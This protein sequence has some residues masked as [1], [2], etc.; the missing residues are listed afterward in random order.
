MTLPKFRR[1]GLTKTLV[2]DLDET[3]VHCVEDYEN[4]PV[5]TLITVTFPNGERANAGLNFRPYLNECLKKAA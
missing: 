3:L 2:F 5:D 4:K 1:P